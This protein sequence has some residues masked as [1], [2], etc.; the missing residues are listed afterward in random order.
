MEILATY[1]SI[2]HASAF[3]VKHH[4]MLRVNNKPVSL[5]CLKQ[6]DLMGEDVV[7]IRRKIATR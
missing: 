4:A 6:E 2:V 5:V 1:L 3:D 7:N